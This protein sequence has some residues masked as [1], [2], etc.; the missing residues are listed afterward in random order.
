[1]L[2]TLF[3]LEHSRETRGDEDIE[4]ATIETDE[5][6]TLNR[7][8]LLSLFLANTRGCVC[9]TALSPYTGKER[10]GERGRRYGGWQE[11]SLR[12]TE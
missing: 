9:V 8:A 5:H 12:E 6:D 3:F 2:N 4:N 7:Q 1:M 11:C 10:V